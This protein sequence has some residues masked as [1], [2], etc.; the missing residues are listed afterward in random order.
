MYDLSAPASCVMRTAVELGSV[1]DDVRCLQTR[2]QEVT[3][4]GGEIVVDGNY[5]PATDRAVRDFQEVQNLVVDGVA[6]AET[7][8]RL[9]VWFDRPPSGW[10]G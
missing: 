7:A 4:T 9:G 3:V 8:E 6:G 2:L 10:T 5:G 1:G